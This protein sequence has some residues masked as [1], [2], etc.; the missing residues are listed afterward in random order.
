MDMDMDMGMDMGMDMEHG[1]GAWTWVY[2]LHRVAHSIG[3]HGSYIRED[4]SNDRSHDVYGGVGR[5][6]LEHGVR[7]ECADGESAREGDDGGGE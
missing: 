5:G 3:E 6:A 1:H 4:A 2:G 7:G